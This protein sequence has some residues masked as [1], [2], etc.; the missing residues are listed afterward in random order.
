M[1]GTSFVKL[2]LIPLIVKTIF[3]PET[4]YL[5]ETF[6]SNSNYQTTAQ[7]ILNDLETKMEEGYEPTVNYR[8]K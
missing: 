1:V 3:Y 2:N 5:N 6:N 4:W 7:F 8:L